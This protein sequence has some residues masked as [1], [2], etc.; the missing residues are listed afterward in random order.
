LKDKVTLGYPFDGVLQF[1]TVSIIPTTLRH[2]HGSYELILA[3]DSIV[4]LNTS[5]IA[6]VEMK[7]KCQEFLLRRSFSAYFHSSKPQLH[8]CFSTMEYSG[9]HI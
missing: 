1:T 3:T 8:Y 7:S 9:K 6:A 2:H 4:T 5:A